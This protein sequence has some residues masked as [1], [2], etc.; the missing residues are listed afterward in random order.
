MVEWFLMA[1]TSDA[2]FSLSI[3]YTQQKKKCDDKNKYLLTDHNYHIKNQVVTKRPLTPL[4]VQ[5]K[6]Y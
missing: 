6:S 3:F 4:F 5:N 1:R 2:R